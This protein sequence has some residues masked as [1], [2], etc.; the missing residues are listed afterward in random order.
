M[1]R[2]MRLPVWLKETITY[3]LVTSIL[4]L[5]YLPMSYSVR[6]QIQNHYQEQTGQTFEKS[7]ELFENSLLQLYSTQE[8]ANSSSYY[9]ECAAAPEDTNIERILPKLYMASQIVSQHLK[10]ISLAD[11]TFVIFPK[12]NATIDGRQVYLDELSFVK[13]GLGIDSVTDDILYYLN[14]PGNRNSQVA[15]ITY[16][17]MLGQPALLLILDYNRSSV[18]VG[19]VYLEETMKELF[20]INSLPDNSSLVVSDSEGNTLYQYGGEIIGKAYTGNTGLLN[21]EVNLIVPYE[22]FNDMLTSFDRMLYTTSVSAG[23]IGLLL[24]VI[25]ALVNYRPVR[26]LV[27]MT[28]ENKKNKNEYQILFD[29][30]QSSNRTIDSLNTHVIAL[31]ESLRANLFAC[32]LNESIHTQNEIEMFESILPI[33]KDNCVLALTTIDADEN[34]TDTFSFLYPMMREGYYIQQTD[35]KHVVI[36]YPDNEKLTQKLIDKFQHNTEK[37]HIG[38]SDAFCGASL[39][40]TAFYHSQLAVACG[41]TVNY[42]S[43]APEIFHRSMIDFNALQRILEL[44]TAGDYMTVE[45]A[46]RSAGETLRVNASCWDECIQLCSIIHFAFEM[47]L[48]DLHF[49]IG[50]LGK[51]IH[52]LQELISMNVTNMFEA[53]IED[54]LLIGKKAQE[55]KQQKN[56]RISDT[57][58]EYINQ[59]YWQSDLYAESIS[60][61][62]GVTMNYVYR[63]VRETTGRSLGE[64][65]EELRLDKACVMLSETNEAIKEISEK[66]GWQI[67]GTFYRV[68]KQH[69]GITPSQYRKQHGAD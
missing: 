35:Y 11:E 17:N 46:I 65:V 56:D 1:D 68:F 25:F 54:A 45:K 4:C 8:I 59:N 24:S 20:Y 6:E 60:R 18:R 13:Y 23:G 7:M 50:T 39:L 12:I 49:D 16:E 47:A 42:F 14:S 29:S 19:A 40:H 10:T 69:F 31:E 48:S 3:L 30:M 26:K 34:D 58:M 52:N 36:L 57:V 22:Y 27:S 2:K 67:S 51:P 37:Y 63:V 43:A 61:A 21:L 33:I 53:L 64:Y 15:Q 41:E 38:I 66:C 32:F 28:G 55:I 9:R 62:L 44:L 5:V